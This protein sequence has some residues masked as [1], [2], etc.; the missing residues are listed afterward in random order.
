LW[1]RHKHSYLILRN[2]TKVSSVSASPNSSAS[3]RTRICP[4]PTKAVLGLRN[5]TQR[6]Q[7][8]DE[9]V[10]TTG[11]EGPQQFMF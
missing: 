2:K 11:D 1:L 10:R 8:A 6:R 9:V 5:A 3:V 7:K 4:D